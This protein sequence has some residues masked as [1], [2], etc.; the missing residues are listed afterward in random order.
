ML[1]REGEQ[2]SV[3]SPRSDCP[4]L[5]R[6][7]HHRV[8]HGP[9]EVR[10]RFVFGPPQHWMIVADRLKVRNHGIESRRQAAMAHDVPDCMDESWMIAG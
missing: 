10:I 8:G 6:T 7:R 4:T 5:A 9:H 2:L 1:R 3:T